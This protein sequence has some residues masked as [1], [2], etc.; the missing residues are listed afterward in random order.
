MLTIQDVPG[1][2]NWLDL[3]TPD[4]EAASTFY[5]TLFGWQFESVGPQGGGYGF[6]RLNGKAVGACGPLPEE[7]GRPAWTP[8]FHTR[9]ADITEKTVEQAGGGVRAAPMDI[10]D[11]G[12]MAQFTDPGGAR[13]A[14]W[15]PR[16]LRG[17]E[18]VND[19]GTLCWTELHV[20][21]PAAARAFYDS[22][23]DWDFQEMPMGDFTYTVV[24]PHEGGE[25]AAFGGIMPL[26]EGASPRWVPYINVAD[27]DAAV[28]RTQELDGSV[29]RPA[30]T[31]EG[32]G[33]MARLADPFGAVFSVITPTSTS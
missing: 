8:Y 16:E 28:A 18:A 32:I 19:P 1:T 7:T 14:V 13:F 24:S 17:L 22:V 5:G 23:F 26:S 30:E 6:F 21:D 29:V 10:F 33:R 12:R 15:Q 2:P 31:A 11:S 20:G 3:A 27:C 9:D 25:D 4:V